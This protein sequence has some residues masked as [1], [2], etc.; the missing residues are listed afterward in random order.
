MNGLIEPELYGHLCRQ[1]RNAGKLY[2]AELR[3]LVAPLGLA[4]GRTPAATAAA[5]PGL[6]AR[7]AAGL[8][9]SA[10]PCRC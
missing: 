9:R 4:V 2:K 1:T 10:A 6:A 8:A 5:T 7:P 3:D